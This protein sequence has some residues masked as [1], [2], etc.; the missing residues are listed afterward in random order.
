MTSMFVLRFV[1][2]SFL[3]F[4]LAACSARYEPAEV[5][6]LDTSVAAQ[7]A[8]IVIEGEKYQVQAG[9]TLFAIA[10]YSGNDYR[11]LA[12]WNRISPPF[13][14]KVGQV[15][16]LVPDQTKLSAPKVVVDDTKPQAYGGKKTQKHRKK[17][18]KNTEISNKPSNKLQWIWPAQGSYSAAIVGSDGSNRGL[19]IKGSV[20]SAIIAAAEGKVVYAGNALK[21]YGNLVIIKHNNDYLS[22]YAHNEKILVNE[23]QY[24]K[25]GQQIATMGRSDAREVML[26]FEIRQRGR[27]LNPLSFLPKK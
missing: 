16:N 7:N 3:L 9:D 5:I 20:G 8:L 12:R 24:V 13:N 6:A 10:L 15:I 23:Q 2:L 14:I 27:S 21:G 18:N 1:F 22:A 17:R 25:Q 19:D 4:I 26:H 11:D